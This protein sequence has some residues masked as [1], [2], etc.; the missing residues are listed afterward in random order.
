MKLKKIIALCIAA[1]MSVSMMSGCGSKP[2]ESKEDSSETSSD[3]S[4]EAEEI[5]FAFHM[6]K[7]VDLEPIENALNEILVP[8]INV[9]VNLEGYSWSNYDTQISLMQSGGEQIDVFGMCPNFSTY[10]TNGQ[11]MPMDGLID[12]YASESKELIGEEFLKCTSKGE[13]VYALPV[14]GAKTDVNGLALRKDL[15]DELNLPVDEIKEAATFEEYVENM[16]VLTEIFTAIHEAHPE[17]VLVPGSQNPASFRV[18]DIPFTDKIG[19]E[20]GVLMDGNDSEVVNM[21]ASDEFKTLTDYLYQWNQSG[22]ILEDA[23]TTQESADTYMKNGRAFAYFELGSREAEMEN[24][25]KKST[26]YDVVYKKL[27][28]AFV[29]TNMV[30][31]SAF[32]ISVTSKHPEASMKFLNEMY[33]NADIV[34]ILS[35]GIEGTHWEQKDDGTIGYPEGVNADNSTYDLGMYWYFGNTFLNKT[36][37]GNVPIDVDAEIEK[38]RNALISPALGFTYDSTVVSTELAAIGNVT[39]QYLPGILCGFLNPEETIPEFL[40]ALESAGIDKVITEKQTQ[41]DA[42]MEENK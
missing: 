25:I 32:G 5:V 23:M 20:I 29:T 36:W 13:S 12:E 7:T 19:D 39:S 3:A 35:W 33:T 42:W 10:L 15:V 21:Y 1:F 22:F 4:G 17:L 11:L 40:D 2:E 16:D 6:G 41:Y 18:T 27:S 37:E 38:N 8:K 9:K 31:N 28:K 14:Y 24:K 30:N 34:N 26:G